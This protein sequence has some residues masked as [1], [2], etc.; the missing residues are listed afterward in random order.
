MLLKTEKKDPYPIALCLVAT[1]TLFHK[2]R[3]GKIIFKNDLRNAVKD[4]K[5][6][7]TEPSKN[8][9]QDRISTQ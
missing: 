2:K 6:Q 3:K 8:R 5:E 1:G 9:A 4:S 7:R